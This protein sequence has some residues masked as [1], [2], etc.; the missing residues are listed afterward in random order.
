MYYHRFTASEGFLNCWTKVL[1][2]VHKHTLTTQT[3]GYF[4]KAHVLTPVHAGLRSGAFAES[5]L[6]Y[7]HL[8]APLKID[9]DN[10]NERHIQTSSD[11]KLANMK[12]KGGVTGQQHNGALTS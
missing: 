2:F 7:T 3:L 1:R 6:V 10:N 11:F 8:K 5:G 4:V 12:H 9:T